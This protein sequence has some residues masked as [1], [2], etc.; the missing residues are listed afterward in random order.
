VIRSS[1]IRL[2]TIA[3]AVALTP[4]LS[5]CEA[6]VNA[7]TTRPFAP[8]D[9]ASTV[10]H[11]IAIRNAFV[12]GPPPAGTLQPGQSAGFF[13]A[14][15]NGGGPDQL[16]AVTAPGTAAAVVIRGAAVPLQHGQAA[17]LTGPEP[18]VVLERLTRPLTG[19]ES[20]AVT[21]YFQNAGAVTLS[22][23]VVTWMDYYATFSPPPSPS[24]S[25]TA[26]PAGTS[27]TAT[28]RGSA[29]GTAKPTPSVTP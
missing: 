12:L 4:V 29:T 5:G 25:A 7:Q 23:P 17:L 6:G 15:I 10:F 2:L 16:T 13:L 27:A 20:I 14:L 11:G 8:T 26:Q 3:A 19:G 9:G 28:P 21:L 1:A 18:Q 22:I 24:P